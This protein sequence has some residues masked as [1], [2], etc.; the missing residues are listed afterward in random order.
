[1]LGTLP[2]TSIAPE[3]RPSQKETS[4]PTIHFQG[5]AVS[6]RVG[7]FHEPPQ[8][9]M[10]NKGV[11]LKPR[12]LLPQKPSKHVGFGGPMVD[13][14]LP[15]YEVK[16]QEITSAAKVKTGK[17]WKQHKWTLTRKLRAPYTDCLLRIIEF[18]RNKRP[19]CYPSYWL[20]A[21]Q[22]QG[23]PNPSWLAPATKS[24]NNL[25]TWAH[26]NMTAIEAYKNA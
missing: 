2:E 11:G 8:K 19:S 18:W 17:K 22:Q 10:K 21:G 15:R 4:I 7:S 13:G 26:N 24:V 14:D 9:P 20:P 5:R 1:M 25:I 16:I 12:F 6:F 23:I 3:N